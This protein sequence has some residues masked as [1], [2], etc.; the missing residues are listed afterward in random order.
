MGSLDGKVALVTGSSSGIGEASAHA[1]AAAGANVVVN[2]SSSVEAGR[3]VA[4]ALATDGHYIQGDISDETQCQALVEGTIERFGRLDIL[5]N[6]AGWTT[7]VDHADHAALTNEILFKTIEVNVYGTW[8]MCKAAMP[9]LKQTD[10][11]DTTDFQKR[12]EQAEQA[13]SEGN[14]SQAI[15]LADGVVRT[16]ERERAAMDDVLRAL[17]QQKN[18]IKRR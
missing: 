10:G 4:A 14:A 1:L 18:L 17:K 13:L 15:G 12:I 5:V 9:H 6:N 16:I 3:A 8:W 11:L 7:R 2:S